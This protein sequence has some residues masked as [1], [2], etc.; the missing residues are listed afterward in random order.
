MRQW[1]DDDDDDH[2]EQT[3]SCYYI[4]TIFLILVLHTCHY[5]ITSITVK[6]DSDDH[7]IQKE[8]DNCFILEKYLSHW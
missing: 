8:I 7:Y 3:I 1:H 5:N 2:D 4:L 6:L